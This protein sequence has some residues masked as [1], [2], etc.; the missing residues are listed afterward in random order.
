[1]LYM[2]GMDMIMMDIDCEWSS[3]EEVGQVGFE[4]DEEAMVAV[5]AV[6]VVV[7]VEE[8]AAAQAVE[9]ALLHAGHNTESLLQVSY[10]DAYFTFIRLF[11]FYH[12]YFII[13]FLLFLI[14]L[15]FSF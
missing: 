14:Y 11:K 2:Q 3:H 6:V 10:L 9:G 5:A 13:A 4:V 7:V 15:Y 1:M 8:V 12:C